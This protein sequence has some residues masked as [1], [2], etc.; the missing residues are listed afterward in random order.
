MLTTHS[1][2][3]SSIRQLLFLIT[4]TVDSCSITTGTSNIGRSCIHTGS[5]LITGVIDIFP[6][7]AA[8]GSIFCRGCLFVSSLPTCDYLIFF[9]N[10]HNRI[11]RIFMHH[12]AV[13]ADF[14]C[15]TR[16]F[17]WQS[18]KDWFAI[19]W[20]YATF[21]KSGSKTACRETLLITITDGQTELLQRS[22][23]GFSENFRDERAQPGCGPSPGSGSRGWC[24][25]HKFQIT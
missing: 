13:I 15:I 16:D 14:G 6:Q 11:G 22:W 9:Q 8:A 23:K 24:R 19:Q 3:K 2:T 5:L 12:T 17:R 21:A 20:H 1:L 4:N 18:T 25:V 10:F 7:D